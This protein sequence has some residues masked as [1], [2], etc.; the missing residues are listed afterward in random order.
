VKFN[1]VDWAYVLFVI[2]NFRNKVE[3]FLRGAFSSQKNK[4]MNKWS[5]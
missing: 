5:G 4:N 1:A 2:V 3:I